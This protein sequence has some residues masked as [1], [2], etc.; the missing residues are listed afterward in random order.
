MKNLQV[1]VF[2]ADSNVY[3]DHALVQIAGRVGRKKDAPEGEVIFIGKTKTE[4]MEKAISDINNANEA[5]QN[6]L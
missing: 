2:H 3:D 1:I 4:Y 5:L 6:M